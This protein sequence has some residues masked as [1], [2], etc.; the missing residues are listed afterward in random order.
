[1]FIKTIEQKYYRLLEKTIGLEIKEYNSTKE[2]YFRSKIGIE[3]GGPSTVFMPKS[4]LPVYSD[5]ALIDGVNFST[6]TVWE[7]E[8]L[9]GRTYSYIKDKVGFQFISEA[10]KL[11]D[12]KNE[13]YD[14][15]ISSHCLEHCANALATVREWSRVV[16]TGGAILILVPNKEHTFDHRRP[17]T[18]FDHLV[19][20]LEKYT[21]E[22]DLSHFDE[23]INLHDLSIDPG[24]S[25]LEVFK[26]RSLNNQKNRCFHHHV[27]DLE[28]LERVFNHCGIKI[29]FK[30]KF[31]PC[32][33][34][35][36]GEKV[37]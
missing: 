4:A 8:I 25:D 16:K 19:D 3:I 15:L 32:H 5:A 13:S 17:T 36:M 1:M 21:A 24:G 9:P 31:H 22:N 27:F 7:N 35:V 28:L 33:L 2:K 23:I 18:S 11:T 37:V 12:I 29:I 30:A 10:S 6:S 34:I 20:D 14:F 26:K